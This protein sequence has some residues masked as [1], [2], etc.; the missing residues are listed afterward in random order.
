MACLPLGRTV[1]ISRKSIEPIV[2]GQGIV[3]AGCSVAETVGTP[4]GHTGRG[5]ETPRTKLREQGGGMY[6]GGPWLRPGGSV[7]RCAYHLDGTSL[8]VRASVGRRTLLELQALHS[9]EVKRGHNIR[10][11]VSGLQ[12]EGEGEGGSG[13]GGAGAGASAGAGAGYVRQPR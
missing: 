8:C 7:A 1:R 10:E 4:R 5:A 13:E 12:G 9:W 11:R 6:C 2:P 3:S